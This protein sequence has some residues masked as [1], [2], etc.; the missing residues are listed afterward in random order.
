[1]IVTHSEFC[2]YCSWYRGYIR[3]GRDYDY[4]TRRT[5]AGASVLATCA[6]RNRLSPPTLWTIIIINIQSYAPQP[7]NII[8]IIMRRSKIVASRFTRCALMRSHERITRPFRVRFSLIVRFRTGFWKIREAPPPRDC[9]ICTRVSP[10]SHDIIFNCR[11][12]T[13]TPTFRKLF[14]DRTSYTSYVV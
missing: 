8:I 11:F 10:L 1:M 9:V 14:H 3:R 7:Y 6:R 4:Y 5:S 2:A 12:P 13:R